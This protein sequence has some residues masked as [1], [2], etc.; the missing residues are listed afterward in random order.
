[1]VKIVLRDQVVGV[2][3]T[4]ALVLDWQS[5]VPITVRELISERVQMEY[6]DLVEH[7]GAYSDPLVDVGPG[8]VDLVEN[9]VTRALK[10]FENRHFLIV[11]D[12]QQVTSLD[13]TISL[14]PTTDVTFLRLTPL[15]GG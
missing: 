13:D 7:R 5:G 8:G 1:M 9:V 11:V 6:S 15:V 14:L 4:H 3:P 2:P 10:G 12:E